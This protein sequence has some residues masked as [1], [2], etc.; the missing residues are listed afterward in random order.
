MPKIGF[1]MDCIWLSSITVGGIRSQKE[2]QVS[3]EQVF[4]GIKYFNSIQFKPSYWVF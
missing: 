1:E 4:L 3:E 2:N